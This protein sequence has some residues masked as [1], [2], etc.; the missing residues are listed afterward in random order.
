MDGGSSN[1]AGAKL[2]E[3]EAFNRISEARSQA[4]WLKA[5]QAWSS[6]LQTLRRQARNGD[7]VLADEPEPAFELQSERSV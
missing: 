2:A 4:D 7:P 6:T 1:W 3:R 5:W